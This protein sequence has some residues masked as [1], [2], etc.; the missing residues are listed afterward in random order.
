[1]EMVFSGP[2]I[3]LVV[4]FYW[5]RC[6]WEDDRDDRLQFITI[7]GRVCRLLI[8][9][10]VFNQIRIAGRSEHPVLHA[11]VDQ[12]TVPRIHL[13]EGKQLLQG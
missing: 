9:S 11:H 5:D 6:S 3:G 12:L 2:R 13:L 4:Q 1:M 10:D 8:K 7:L